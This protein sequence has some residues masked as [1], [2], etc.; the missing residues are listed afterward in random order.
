MLVTTGAWLPLALRDHMLGLSEALLGLAAVMA[1]KF[2]AALGDKLWIA[3]LSN[4]DSWSM[5]NKR[6]T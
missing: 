4:R 5:Q 6:A 2:W 3:L 1:R